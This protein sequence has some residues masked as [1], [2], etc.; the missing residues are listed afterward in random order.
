M[1]ILLIGAIVGLLATGALP[2]DDVR[3]EEITFSSHSTKLAGSL[4]LPKDRAVTAAVVFVHG[5]GRQTR[6]MLWARR[7]AAE[8]IAAFVYDKRGA[9]ASEGSYEEEQS[10][11]EKNI[12]L[13][14]DDAAAAFDAISGRDSLKNVPIGFAGISQA[15]WIVPIAAAKCPSSKFVV[16]W[17]GPVCRVSEEDIYSKYTSDRDADE[18]PPYETALKSRTE[19]YVWPDFLGKDTDPKESLE[20][21]SIPGLWI[22]GGRDGSIPVDLSIDGLRE[23]QR[24]GRA[25]EYVLFSASGHN[26]MDETFATAVDWIR[27]KVR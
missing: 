23:L 11:G 15:G 7:F 4:V 26:N 3:V 24:K 27:R 25:Y 17:S 8:G 1:N 14:A 9:G 16:L 13:L 22:F 12:T 5:S 20:K 19:Q 2:Q 6:S 18:A 21:L 10:V